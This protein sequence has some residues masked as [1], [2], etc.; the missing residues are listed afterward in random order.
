MGRRSFT[1]GEIDDLRRLIR[2]KQMADR[3]RQKALRARIR[4][5]GFYISDFASDYEGSSSPIWTT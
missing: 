5:I 1:P 4:R 2:E 3:S